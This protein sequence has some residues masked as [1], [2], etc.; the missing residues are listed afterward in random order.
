M[1]K[2]SY[3]GPAEAL[4]RYEALVATNPAVER[5]G[6]K[7][8][9]T[10]RN[11]HMFSFL[12]PDGTM[13]LRLP[14]DRYEEFLGTYDSGPVESYG[15]VMRGYVSVPADLLADTDALKP[16]F[17]AGHEWIGTLKPKPTKKPAKKTAKKPAKKSP[18]KSARKTAGES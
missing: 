7:N 18:K 4:D 8:P 14:V 11:G 13:A 12:G 9:Y 6:A 10:S 5:K 1:A 3:E 15:A 16:W 17:D 2:P